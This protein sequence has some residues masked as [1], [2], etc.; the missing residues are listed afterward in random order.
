MRTRT[1]RLVGLLLTVLVTSLTVAG[2]VW[3]D[4]PARGAAQRQRFD[5]VV[6]KRLN[7]SN[8]AIFSGDVEVAGDVD[9][10]GDMT[11]GGD[12]TVEGDTDLYG[13]ITSSEA[14]ITLTDLVHI[15]GARDG[16]T[17]YDYFV[18]VE[19]DLDGLGN[20]AKTYGQYISVERPLGS[21]VQH[22]NIDDAGLKIRVETNAITTVSGYVLNGADIQAKTDNNAVQPIIRGAQI[23]ADTDEDSSTGE[24]YGLRVY[25]EGEGEITTTMQIAD[26]E[27]SRQQA[28]DPTY[29]YGLNIRNTSRAGGGADVALRIESSYG[30]GGSAADDNWDYLIDLSPADAAIADLRFSQGETVDNLVDGVLRATGD[31]SVTGALTVQNTSDLQGDIYDSIGDVTVDDNLDVTG[32]LD[33]QGGDITLENDETISNGTNGYVTVT[34]PAAGNFGVE[35]GNLQVGDGTPLYA[36]MDGAD[37]FLAGVLEVG[38][39]SYFDSGVN[40]YSTLN[41]V[42]TAIFQNTVDLQG[43]VSDSTTDLMVNDNLNVS[44]NLDV[45]GNIVVTG[46]IS[47]PTTDLMVN[48]NLN[49]SGSLDVDGAL[50]VTGTTELRNTLDA[51]GLVDNT[52][53]DLDLRDNVTVTGDVDISGGLVVT[54]TS[55]LRGYI[56]DG[57]DDLDLRDNVT[58]TGNVDVSGDLVVTNTSELRG[59]VYDAIDDLDFR[60]NV[61][62][63]GDVD[64]SGNLVV[65]DTSELRGYVYDSIDDLDLRDN[66]T[67]TGNVDVSGGLVVTGATQLRS[68]LDIWGTISDLDS[69]LDITDDVTVTGDVDIGANLVVTGT[70]DLLGNV[71][72]SQGNFTIADNVLIDGQ[73][74]ATQLIVQGHGPGEQ[75]LNLLVCEESGG[76]DMFSVG[77]TGN[78]FISGTLDVR[79]TVSD[80]DS[81]LDITDDITVTGDVDIGANLTVTGTSDFL[82]NVGDSQGDLTFADH[83]SITQNLS[84]GGSGI[85]T[86][87][88]DVDDIFS[89][90][91]ISYTLSGAQSWTPVKSMFVGNP[92]AADLTLTL[93]TGSAEIGDFLYV[94]N[95]HA[96]N[97]ITIVDTGAT[98]GGGDRRLDTDDVIG[99]IWVDPIWVEAFYSD[100]S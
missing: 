6:T 23:T 52:V 75:S 51:Q 13:D 100:N 30:A 24:A 90:G 85:I 89:L 36:P 40:M 91:V 43:A 47:D 78:T 53:A 4:D 5:W 38:G 41:V 72:D 60:D 9:F 63:T 10:E 31:I 81:D 16:T 61:T 88:L 17:G 71:G 22:G 96:T 44:G 64:V 58:V 98:A 34:V 67:V 15:T 86:G 21:S 26:F 12:L 82:G 84:V 1:E 65:T 68:T 99:F 39:I 27:L 14:A 49:V 37:T 42:N 77:P 25:V 50:I 87:D 62:I 19:G 8:L 45:T 18:T 95:I 57:V 46:T 55:E 20:G 35:G 94:V 28:T 80:G 56:F 76:T 83:V 69:D 33:V 66:V 92:A 29:E 54:G 74:N 70:S 32:A 48:D 11:I 3:A 93:G 2:I 79:G 97:C 7:V 73:A 59:Y